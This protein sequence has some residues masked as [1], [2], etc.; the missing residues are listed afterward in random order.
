MSR[1]ERVLIVEDDLSLMPF[2]SVILRRCLKGATVD[3]AVSCE[4]AR[5]L[6]ELADRKQSPYSMIIAD[7]FLAGSDTGLDLLNS[8]EVERS[9]ALKLLVTSAD[10]TALND[11]GEWLKPSVAV[12]SKPLSV[13]KCERVLESMLTMRQKAL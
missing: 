7:I 5:E 8:P 6:M 4:R 9:S 11:G 12:L 3:W 13:P 2:W 10:E 1:N